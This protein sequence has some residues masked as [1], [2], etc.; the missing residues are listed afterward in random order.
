MKLD[1]S[2]IKENEHRVLDFLF[3]WV[4]PIRVGDLKDHLDLKHSTLN[5]ILSRLE[6]RGLVDWKKYGPV[7]LSKKGKEHAAHLSNHHFI[8]EKFFKEILELPQKLA[9]K[10]ALHLAGAFSCD[11]IEAICKKLG[12]SQQKNLNHFCAGREYQT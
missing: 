8:I 7:Q 6:S 10:E 4:R 5:S 11:I 9:H 3:Y 1:N 12:I 2:L